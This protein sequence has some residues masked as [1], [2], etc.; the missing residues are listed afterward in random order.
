MSLSTIGSGATC[1]ICLDTMSPDQKPFAHEGNGQFHPFHSDCIKRAL[2]VDARCPIC[3]AVVDASPLLTT[4]EKILCSIQKTLHDCG[5]AILNI[6]DEQRARQRV[7]RDH[8]EWGQVD[9]SL[10]ILSNGMGCMLPLSH[11]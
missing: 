2:L 3:R 5:E 4:R 1:P 10:V 6:C 11:R 8:P 7:M 9:Y